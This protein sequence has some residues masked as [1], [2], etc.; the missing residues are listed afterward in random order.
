MKKLLFLLL[1]PIFSTSC[2]KV[3]NDPNAPFIVKEVKYNNVYE[4]LVVMSKENKEE[5]IIDAS[6]DIR[7]GDTLYV[8]TQRE[9]H[10]LK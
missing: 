1:I 3:L 4:A 8:I 10:K 2:V 5:L 7:Y 6:S 9:L